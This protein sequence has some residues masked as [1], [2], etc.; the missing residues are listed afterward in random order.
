[1]SEFKNYLSNKN[2]IKEEQQG[3]KMQFNQSVN[4]QFKDSNLSQAPQ[5]KTDNKEKCY[6]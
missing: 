6:E 1:M 4:S 3:S 2:K 5:K